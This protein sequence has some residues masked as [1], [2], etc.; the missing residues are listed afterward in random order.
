MKF[1]SYYSKYGRFTYVQFLGK[2][3]HFWW[4]V[5]VCLSCA[6]LCV[7][8]C[9]CLLPEFLSYLKWLKKN[10]SNAFDT[11]WKNRTFF[12]F[13][14]MSWTTCPV[15]GIMYQKTGTLKYRGIVVECNGNCSWLLTLLVWDSRNLSY[16]TFVA[17]CMQEISM[18]KLYKLVHLCSETFKQYTYISYRLFSLVATQVKKPG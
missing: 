14:I 8:T 3:L 17:N 6:H 1:K 12:F 5:L 4:V 16:L 2:Y 11:E 7:R 9:H 13:P 15:C 18:F 10:I